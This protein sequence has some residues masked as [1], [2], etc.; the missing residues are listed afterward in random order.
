MSIDVLVFSVSIRRDACFARPENASRSI[1]TRR[2]MNERRCRGSP[3]FSATT[4]GGTCRGIID[5]EMKPVLSAQAS[6][7]SPRRGSCARVTI[8]DDKRLAA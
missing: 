2:F 8:G 7:S 3:C 6:L 5:G 4:Y 1:E